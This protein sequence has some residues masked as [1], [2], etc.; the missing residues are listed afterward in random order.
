MVM[1]VLKNKATKCIFPFVMM[2]AVFGSGYQKDSFSSYQDLNG[3]LIF[4]AQ[5][6][7]MLIA[8][9]INIPIVYR[10]GSSFKFN[11]TTGSISQISPT[12]STS[13]LTSLSGFSFHY[14]DFNHDGHQDM[15]LH[16]LE[17]GNSLE[18][19]IIFGSS[20][21]LS[22]IT[23]SFSD[24]NGYQL[25]DMSVDFK[26]INGDGAKELIFVTTSNEEIP[27]SPSTPK[28]KNNT[29]PR[30]GDE[31]GRMDFSASVTKG[32]AATVSV[33]LKSPAGATSLLASV[34]MTYNSQYGSGNMGRGW[35]V[36]ALDFISR[37]QK[38]Y[39]NNLGLKYDNSDAFCYQGER[40]VPIQGGNGIANTLY[41]T[42]IDTGVLVQSFGT[43]L[44]GPLYWQT[45][46]ADGTTTT[47][48][49]STNSR[50]ERSDSLAVTDWAQ[51]TR[52]LSSGASYTA[53]YH[54]DKENGEQYL[55]KIVYDNQNAEIDFVWEGRAD[56]YS[57]WR[58]GAKVL[59]SKRLANVTMKAD[60]QTQRIYKVHYTQD[61][62]T[63]KP[64]VIAIQE[65]NATGTCL[66]PLSFGWHSVSDDNS[67]SSKATINSLNE[68]S[69]VNSSSLTGDINGDGHTDLI[70]ISKKS[71]GNEK[72][73]TLVDVFLNEGDGSFE[74][75]GLLGLSVTN[76]KDTSYSLIDVNYDGYADF[77]ETTNSTIRTQFGSAV[78]GDKI[79]SGVKIH[80][81]DANDTITSFSD[82]NGDG[83]PELVAHSALSRNGPFTEY[84][85]R[86]FKGQG[87]G[88]YGGAQVFEYLADH[89][90][91]SP[92][93]I[94]DIDGDGLSEL[95]F[96]N[97]DI[98][99]ED[100]YSGNLAM[101]D[102]YRIVYSFIDRNFNTTRTVAN[103]PESSA[104]QFVDLTNDGTPDKVVE[105]DQTMIYYEGFGNGSFNTVGKTLPL[106]YKRTV[107]YQELYKLSE[108]PETS[109]LKTR[110][111][112]FIDINND[113]RTD[114]VEHRPS[115]NSGNY[116][117]KFGTAEGFSASQLVDGLSADTHSIALQFLDLN[118]DGIN[119]ALTTAGDNGQIKTHTS[120]GT[121]RPMMTTVDDGFG[122]VSTFH[123]SRMTDRYAYTKGTDARPAGEK[124]TI[125]NSRLVWKFDS[126]SN[127][128]FYKY[129]GAK[130]RS[131]KD[132]Y[133]GFEK[134]VKTTDR[135]ELKDRATGEQQTIAMV[136][137]T[138]LMQEPPFI[139]KTD[140]VT[141]YNIL[142]TAESAN[143]EVRF[144]FHDTTMELDPY[145]SNTDIGRTTKLISNWR[146]NLWGELNANGIKDIYLRKYVTRQYDY[147]NQ[148][149]LLRQTEFEVV[150]EIPIGAFFTRNSYTVA[151][152]GSNENGDYVSTVTKDFSYQNGNTLYGSPSDLRADSSETTYMEPG[153]QTLI[154][155]D[156]FE[157]Y[158]DGRLKNHTTYTKRPDAA[159]S[160]SAAAK[161]N[162]EYT[163][164]PISTLFKKTISN[165]NRSVGDITFAADRVFY[166]DFSSAYNY[167]YLTK[168]T[169]ILDA[170]DP[171]LDQSTTY[172]RFDHFG[173]AKTVRQANGTATTIAVDDMGRPYAT[174][175]P[176]G[177]VKAKEHH[178]CA[179]AAESRCPTDAVYFSK[180]TSKDGA[181]KVAPTTYEYF[182][183]R[184]R[185]VGSATQLLTGSWS[186]SAKQWDDYNR[187]T[188][189]TTPQD[190][191]TPYTSVVV[192]D[193]YTKKYF[194]DLNDRILQV[195]QQ[196]EVDSE[197]GDNVRNNFYVVPASGGGYQK[198][199]IDGKGRE[200]HENYNAKE[201]LTS[202]QET[203]TFIHENGDLSTQYTTI[204]HHYDVKGRKVK[205]TYPALKQ[206]GDIDAISKSEDV[207]AYND[208]DG[209]STESIPD[210][211]QLIQS[212][213]NI[214][215]D[216]VSF[217]DGNLKEITSTFDNLGRKIA[218]VA[219]GELTCWYYDK[220]QTYK[221]STMIGIGSLDSVVTYKKDQ[222]NFCPS[223]PELSAGKVKIAKDYKLNSDGLLA[224]ETV[225]AD[226]LTFDTKHSYDQSGRLD[227][228]TLP[229]AYGT[230]TFADNR[231]KPKTNIQIEYNGFGY[232]ES[233]TNGEAGAS[234]VI[235]QTNNDMDAFGNIV[236][237]MIGVTAVTTT[238][239][240]AT[241]RISGI[242]ARSNGTDIVNYGYGFNV[243]GEITGRWETVTDR[244]ERFEYL[245]GYQRQITDV[246]V[247]EY[248]DPDLNSFVSY[249]EY[250]YDA[251]GNIRR[252]IFEDNKTGVWHDFTYSYSGKE[253]QYV[254]GTT[255]RTNG[256]FKDG[257]IYDE[258]GNVTKLGSNEMVYNS[259]NAVTRLDR[260]NNNN[261]T[262]YKYDES[263][264][265]Y[266]REA[267]EYGRI[268]KAYM[269]GSYERIERNGII[270]HRHYIGENT[271]V[272]ATEA[273]VKHTQ[274]FV[275]D[276]IGSVVAIVDANGNILERKR[277]TIF[278]E[279]ILTDQ[280]PTQIPQSLG[281]TEKGFT[282]HEH[283][284]GFEF[285]HMGGRLYHPMLGRFMQ[286]DPFLQN[287]K[288]PV[289]YGRYNYVMNNPLGYTDPSG[290]RY[291]DAWANNSDTS[292][293]DEDS[294]NTASDNDSMDAGLSK[295]E[296]D[297]D[298]GSKKDGSGSNDSEYSPISV[299]DGNES[300]GVLAFLV[301]IFGPAGEAH[302]IESEGYVTT[303][304]HLGAEGSAQVFA[305]VAMTFIPPTTFVG[306]ALLGNMG[307]EE[308]VGETPA[309]T[310][311]RIVLNSEIGASMGGMTKGVFDLV[312][313][314][315]DFA[316]TTNKWKAAQSLYDGKEGSSDINKN[317]QTIFN[318]YTK[319]NPIVTSDACY[320]DRRAYLNAK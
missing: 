32:G 310:A 200:R 174:T 158:T 144:K 270:E 147:S 307:Y 72:P 259:L 165:P 285:I 264:A 120:L 20:G 100:G 210:R 283:V 99:R 15:Y 1:K 178:F 41:R 284:T 64:Q 197:R 126:P 232:A 139:G 205:T 111:L 83:Y 63:N 10:D 227:V 204:Q 277:Y 103:N 28:E 160:V 254:Q 14:G 291:D 138:S 26:D 65:C 60:N 273:G 77:I 287:P 162:Y 208:A 142:S 67:F 305:G 316:F 131:G 37:C 233:L 252:K 141:T 69:Y 229:T 25:I 43:H 226:G 297:L 152:T 250:S 261:Y 8:A 215:G 248:T 30:S 298:S 279:D 16:P 161:T 36:S 177:V 84:W 269:M 216:V 220:T 219:D 183:R 39:P 209:I 239:D 234:K 49:N 132:G 21:T 143:N 29:V 5:E 275:R 112:V 149:R 157:Y 274:H 58:N 81:F 122:N 199:V 286:A 265:R 243:V 240:Q 34:N 53:H 159:E 303:G 231:A 311:G 22:T 212:Q 33:A 289:N 304:T 124:N 294:S 211:N 135:S 85:T 192:E 276:H 104:L 118:A 117:V 196:N 105:G 6:K 308:I 19:H 93:Q 27:K 181:V 108:L 309:Q 223:V 130:Q 66:K 164:E 167:K 194:Y 251:F 116:Y 38:E 89:Y 121:P 224:S 18:G 173:N 288:A 190:S 171:T 119:D 151:R 42:E 110:S 315:G 313:S 145:Y 47:Y 214:F 146:Q 207:Y 71:V 102:R 170:V 195:R 127:V 86:V 222:K 312:V 45:T 271:L 267:N 202:T 258:N 154:D 237:Q 128:E 78:I 272:L 186:I 191:F 201:Q 255:S 46:A 225:Y 320:Y 13:G 91:R 101:Y 203:F 206:D 62:R 113:G 3:S 221:Y 35:S 302:M 242:N 217:K 75:K 198:K 253:L 92:M 70:R 17:S 155:V 98:R 301:R 52:T 263:N 50:F 314:I 88:T 156:D 96:H 290:Y 236:S 282:N 150:K 68:T 56:T 266:Y 55:E 184:G 247:K 278:G 246:L 189:E 213:T 12:Y 109:N 2:G 230:T 97:P 168:T 9:E 175:D 11:S 238:Y 193:S 241:N 182:D 140:L 260:S 180:T 76:E 44:D 293:E 137:T 80:D 94:V 218:Q 318:E 54:N 163:A 281:I 235:Y 172:S 228:T 317:I 268:T 244:E 82:L 114:I 245:D 51:T 87:D 90:A 74:S 123:W 31:V 107:T 148:E 179:S 134:F 256:T 59:T 73:D 153:K 106:K 23:E 40:L 129:A 295:K 24:V 133:L 115:E 176:F 306:I 300:G 79:F 319:F 95:M 257:V 249:E 185:L 299:K 292:S 296:D 125:N 136:T 280:R 61:V 4:I 187:L 57:G 262:L 7:I 188:L 169:Q 48:G 166:T